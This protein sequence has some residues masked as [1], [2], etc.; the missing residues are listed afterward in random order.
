MYWQMENGVYKCSIWHPME[1]AS[2]DVD[3]EELLIPRNGSYND[4]LYNILS[5]LIL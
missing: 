1:V 4:V 2:D 5:L 3:R